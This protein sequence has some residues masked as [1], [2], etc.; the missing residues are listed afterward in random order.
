MKKL[1]TSIAFISYVLVFSQ[2]NINQELEEAEKFTNQIIENNPDK[3][4]HYYKLDNGTLK[5]Y[6]PD[7]DNN[8]DAVNEIMMS[9]RIIK[10]NNKIIYISKSDNF[11]GGIGDWYNAQDFYF[12][13]NG[14]LLGAVKKEEWFLENKCAQQIKFRGLYLNYGNPKLD[15]KDK[16]YNE[17]DKEINLDSPNCKSSKKKVLEIIEETDKIAFRDLEGFMKIE[18]IKY[19]RTDKNE[20]NI[21]YEKEKNSIGNLIEGGEKEVI[22]ENENAENKIDVNRKL[23]SFIP[24]TMGRG[25]IQPSHCCTAKGSITITYTVDKEG[26]VVSARKLGGVSDSCIITTSISWI[27]KYVKAEKSNFSSSG[28]Y[29]IIF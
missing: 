13:N 18:K 16:F 7:N 14:I 5:R 15:R 24:G 3:I 12:D 23:I 21:E 29:R 11:W 20:K 4:S 8:E 28:T 22:L 9:Y 25:G 26:N 6:Y 27:K 1:I 2:K 17:N 10:K 19:Y